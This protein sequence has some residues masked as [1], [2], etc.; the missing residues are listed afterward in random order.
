[1][2]SEPVHIAHVI[3]RFD[4]GGLE[5]GVV[6]LINQLPQNKYRHSII[7]HKGMNP[8]FAARIK[9][10]NVRFYDL[11]KR[12]GQDWGLYR[13]LNRLLKE[14]KPALLHTRNLA[15][16]ESQLVG[17]WRG[18]PLR[19]HGEHG[20]D[21]ADVGGTNP[22]YQRL[23]RLLKPFIHHFIALSSE[24]NQYL[25]D[26]I[27]VPAGKVSHICN[28]VDFDRFAVAQTPQGAVPM[29][30][31]AHTRL[32]FGTVGRLADVKNQRYLV[33]AFAKL[34]ENLGKEAD[35][36]R[37]M[38][39][40]DGGTRTK[41]E[42]QVQE[43]GL[44]K[45]VWFAGDRAD[46][47]AMMQK[48]QVFVLPSLAEGISNTFLEAM[49]S[50]LPVIATD[51]GGNPDLMPPEHVQTNLVPVNQVDALVSAMMRYARHPALAAQEGLQAK[52]YCHRQFSLANMVEKYQQLYQRAGR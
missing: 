17:W 22:K 2:I 38:L 33:E 12:D 51:V 13:R 28:G 43:A 9:T 36:L 50:G 37:L 26:K 21:M 40:G 49:A 10:D 20:W 34:V 46:V 48:M 45:Q 47:P 15:T 24:A 5:N 29:D 35:A 52:Q 3:Y 32:V 7:T 18:I 4:T 11:A 1:M 8:D 41:L 23:R 14:L 31:F 30:F 25:I 44:A 27:G 6:N 19:I 16:I 39:V 42:R